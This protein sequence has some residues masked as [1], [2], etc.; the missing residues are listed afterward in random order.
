[1]LRSVVMARPPAFRERFSSRLVG[2]PEQPAEGE[3]AVASS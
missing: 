1:M 3:A 2:R